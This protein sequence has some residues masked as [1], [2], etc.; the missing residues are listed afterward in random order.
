MKWTITLESCS[1]GFKAS[2]DNDGEVFVSQ[3]KTAAGALALVTE[4]VA[5]HSVGSSMPTP[6]IDKFIKHVSDTFSSSVGNL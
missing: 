1:F 3:A 6:N 4:W 5:R 2:I